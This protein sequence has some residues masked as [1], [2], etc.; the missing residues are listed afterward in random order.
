[1]S[2]A[3]K[4]MPN[5][6]IYQP[7]RD[8]AQAW[9]ERD[10]SAN[11]A[12]LGSLLYEP[13]EQFW[14][15]RRAGK[16]YA[17]GMVVAAEANIPESLP[18]VMLHA[19]DSDDMLQLLQAD[20]PSEAVWTVH[21]AELLAP[22]EQQLGEQHDPERGVRYFIANDTHKPA[23]NVARP[24]GSDDVKLD[25]SP[26]SLGSIALSYW[27]MRGWRVYG[28][29]EDGRLLGHALAAYPIGDT[30]E[31]AAVFTAPEARRRGIASACA[32][33]VIADIQARGKRA[34]YVSR[35]NNHAS[36]A[37]AQGLGM[38]P[39]LETWEIVVNMPAG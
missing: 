23:N 10:L 14:G 18:N 11:L 28:V 6:E 30:E 7:E 31:V 17:L 38:L 1:M 24:L 16:L 33:A 29:A 2:F 15:L 22:L 34:V 20:W 5:N 27:L 19:P 39:L 13:V 21:R 37:V 35:K 36:I 4:T 8:E 26:C 32:A 12:M 25:L 3:G 9:L